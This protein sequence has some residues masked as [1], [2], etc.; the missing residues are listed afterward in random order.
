VEVKTFAEIAKKYVR[1]IGRNTGVKIQWG[2]ATPSTDG[3]TIY[4]PAFPA[5]TVLDQKQEVL[6]N[7]FLDHETAHVRW[8]NITA[9]QQDQTLKTD[10]FYRMIF[11]ILE[12]VRIENA[13]IERY[14]GS[15]RHLDFINADASDKIARKPELFQ[16]PESRFTLWLLQ[17]AYKFRD[18]HYK[19]I[20]ND[21]LNRKYAQIQTL[22]PQILSARSTEDLLPLAK[23]IRELYDEAEEQ[24]SQQNDS[25][26]SQSRSS[27]QGQ[28]GQGSPNGRQPSTQNDRQ[29]SPENSG[30]P[31]DGDN[32]QGS[33]ASPS[34]SQNGNQTGND[35][36]DSMQAL[37]QLLDK[38][39]GLRRLMR[40]VTENNSQSNQEAA[41]LRGQMYRTRMF[42]TRIIPPFTGRDKVFVDIKKNEKEYRRVSQSISPYM[43]AAR[44]FLQLLLQ[45]KN[46]RGWYRGLED[47]ELDLE[48]LPFIRMGAKNVKK[49]HYQTRSMNTAILI[50]VDLSGS[51]EQNST[52]A[53]AILSSEALS[54]F[55]NVKFAIVGF[56]TGET[57]GLANVDAGH[58][59]RI[60]S[61]Y[62]PLFKDFNEPY[63]KARYRLG[64]LS[65]SRYTPLGDAYGKALEKL[66]LRR[67][68]KRILW[69]ISDGEPEFYRG[70]T[71]HCEYSYLMQLHR[72]AKKLHIETVGLEI[73]DKCSLH[74]YVDTSTKIEKPEQ[75]P[76]AMLDLLKQMI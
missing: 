69:I 65:T 49:V 51:M 40:E 71:E 4:L 43:K 55:S 52:T 12:D 20:S 25:Q 45:S 56:T 11:N 9:V 46:R 16:K 30:Q 53:A 10:G 33:T 17:E 22:L 68:P 36:A 23:Q 13:Q 41:S 74:H 61:L 3:D 6:F 66:S 58:Y 21:A 57:D 28:Q 2:A 75:L 14:P 1:V 18:F 76:T 59:G 62:M 73:G 50:L 7:G 72:N 48:A 64:S 34:Q 70:N 54:T 15:K 42:G 31:E 26:E 60:S 47:G 35:G 27:S 19:L 8:T 37:E 38:A 24:D 5:G 29:E 63:G 39:Q 67:E 44:K 32:D